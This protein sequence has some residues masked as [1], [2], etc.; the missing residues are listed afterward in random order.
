MISPRRVLFRIGYAA[1]GAVYVMLGIAAISI[2][3][4]GGRDR[5][6]GFASAFRLLLSHPR[7]PAIVAAIAGG[8]VAFTVARLLDAGDGKRS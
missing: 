1:L 7:G 4:Q 2:A 6:R 5:V 8:L 3:T